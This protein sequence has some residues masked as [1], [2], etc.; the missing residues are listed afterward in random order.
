MA[1]ID[2]QV[3]GTR[4]E[5]LDGE[6]VPLVEA[7]A[8]A[9]D[10]RVDLQDFIDTVDIVLVAVRVFQ[11]FTEHFSQDH[12]VVRFRVD[13]RSSADLVDVEAR[14]VHAFVR[15]FYQGDELEY[16]ADDD[17]CY[18]EL[19]PDFAPCFVRRAERVLP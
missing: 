13:D 3:G 16:A 10:D 6:V 5:H 18:I 17:W 1:V 12:P 14:Q 4:G 11:Y 7:E 19:L 8:F 2:V 9:L 15:E